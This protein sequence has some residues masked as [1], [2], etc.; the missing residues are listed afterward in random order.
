[1][2][3]SGRSRRQQLIRQAE[4]YLELIIS[5]N[6]ALELEPSLRDALAKRCLDRLERCEEEVNEH[7]HLLYLR[8]EAFRTMERY[9]DAIE[10]LT[11]SLKIDPENVHALLALA[12][13]YKRTGQLD[14]AIEALEQGLEADYGLAILH[15]NLACYWSL[16][17]RPRIAL[18]YLTT[19]FEIDS[20]YRDLVADEADFDPIREDPE[21]LALTTAPV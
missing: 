5:G 21:F 20:S 6:S 7:E 12:W 18:L 3:T 15:F 14:L 4:G 2:S 16:K 8:G 13:C 9:D 1:M 17:Q 19:A 11:A 10:A